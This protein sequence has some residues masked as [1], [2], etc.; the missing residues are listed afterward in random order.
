[1]KIDKTFTATMQKSPNTGGWTYVV[2]PD[3]YEFFGTHG[4]VKV[5]GTVNGEPFQSSLMAMGDGVQMLPVKADIRKT[6]GKEA[7][8]EVTVHLTERL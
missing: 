4:A 2:M 3:A 8:D 5:K 7:G 6:I 1:M